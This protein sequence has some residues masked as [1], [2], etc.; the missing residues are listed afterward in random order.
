MIITKYDRAYWSALKLTWKYNKGFRNKTFTLFVFLK[1][2][3]Q[4]KRFYTK[5]REKFKN[6]HNK[7]Q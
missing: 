3:W 5:A 7:Q 2:L 6:D 4:Q 1:A